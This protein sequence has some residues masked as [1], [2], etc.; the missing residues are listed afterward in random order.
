MVSEELTSAIDNFVEVFRCEPKEQAKAQLRQMIEE[1]SLIGK[2]QTSSSVM[3]NYENQIEEL[4]KWNEKLKERVQKADRDLMDEKTA[5]KLHEANMGVV[6]EKLGKKTG[7]HNFLERIDELIEK[8][9]AYFK[10]KANK[11]KK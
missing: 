11:Q 4:K 9:K 1:Q 7:H 3:Q 2:G 5:R 6:I 10:P 8:E